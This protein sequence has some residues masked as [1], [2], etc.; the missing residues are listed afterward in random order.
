MSNVI[1]IDLSISQAHEGLKNK[2]FSSVDLTQAYLD[3][4][5]E[6][7]S[8]LNTYVTVTGDFALEKAK[9]IDEAGDFSSPLA[10]IPMSLKDVVCTAGIKTTASSKILENFVP[11]YNA[12]VADRLF[13]AGAVLL[14]K[15]NTD[16]FTH[17]S[18]TET[19]YFG[20]SKNPWNTDCVP[21]GSSGGSASQV[22]ADLATYS[23]GTDTG[24]SIRQ[25]ASLCSCVGLKVTYGRVPRHGV[26][27]YASSFDTIGPL[28]K[29]VEDAALVLQ[30]IAGRSE[31]DATTPNVPVP[32]YSDS[33][34]TDLKGVKIGIPK[35]Y[36]Q[37]G[38]EEETI[39]VINDGIEVM[40]KL[41]A[42]V[43]DV[44]LPLT[45]YSI[46]TY[47][48]LAKSEASTNLARYDGIKYGHTTDSA[49]KLTEI[50]M[51]SRSEGFGDEVKRAIMIGTYALSAGYYDAFYLKAAK[52]R[53]LMKK[54]FEEAFAKCD[55]LVTPTSPFPAFKI[56]EKADDPL[57]MY[58]ADILTTAV[59]LAGI[60][61]MSIP[62]GF[63]S[64]GLP[65]G[66]QIMANQ[67]KEE[68][69]F[70]AGHAFEQ[71]TE[72]RIKKPNL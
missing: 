30:A 52:V 67:Y 19:S 18:S 56:G 47:Y 41:G 8:K 1:M 64:G 31:K 9:K 26:M 48:L 15:A 5:K 42:E 68:N 17:G 65:I 55:V 70:H 25:P 46:P 35:E 6:L 69:L 51:K 12:H 29:T 37:E 21:G 36:F 44:S 16:E 62:A 2:K 39:K 3:R 4:I 63:S 20:T 45:K 61:A 58:M 54:E 13:D 32:N 66:M 33:L 57:A 27:P 71:A 59:N 38:V 60:C 53:A 50:Y 7:D 43:I 40:K 28:T 24:G 23:I 11:P 10:G 72:W 22:A 34:K 49:K 14:G